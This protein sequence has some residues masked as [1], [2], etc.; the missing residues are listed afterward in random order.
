[1]KDMGVNCVVEVGPKKV[2]CGLAKA[3]LKGMPLLS[4]DVA[5]DLETVT[6][7]CGAPS[8]N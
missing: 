7:E 6:A 2:L 1:M 4:I 5:A 8:A 3:V